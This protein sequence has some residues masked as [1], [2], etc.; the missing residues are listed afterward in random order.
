MEINTRPIGEILS[1]LLR[2]KGLSQSKLAKLSGIDRGYINQIVN[3]KVQSITIRTARALALGM[4]ES[5]EIFLGLA[6]KS[7][8]EETPE[9][10]LE[11]LRISQPVSVPIYEDFPFHAGTP[12]NPA[13]YT[14]VVR[15]QA[16]GKRLE[17]YIVH[18]DCL[19]PD[20]QDGDVI[21]VD[22]E[23]AVDI[24]NIIACLYQGE[25]HMGRLRKIA[26]ELHLENNHGRIKLDECQVA[27]P[28]IEVRRKLK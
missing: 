24:G 3:G 28:V 13:E 27:A 5:P 12:V 19:L 9:D 17:G 6:T 7:S 4:G 15:D 23:G 8:K 16:R 26:D 10:I 21:I 25:L 14:P 20:I 11:H 1:N 22:R 18:G 2:E